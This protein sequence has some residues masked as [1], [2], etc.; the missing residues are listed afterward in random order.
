MVYSWSVATSIS[1][2]ARANQTHDRPRASESTPPSISVAAAGHSLAVD[3]EGQ[4]W[5]W[6]RNNSRGGGGNWY[7]YDGSGQL[8]VRLGDVRPTL[9]ARI[10]LPPQHRAARFAAVASG[11]YHS[12]AVTEGGELLTW[13]SNDHGQLGR[14]AFNAS[15]H[16]EPCELGWYCRD[17]WPRPVQGLPRVK[18]AALGRFNSLAIDEA[19]QIWVWGID[20]CAR[21]DWAAQRRKGVWPNALASAQPRRVPIRE[22]GQ[23]LN[24]TDASAGYVHWVAV[25]E[26]G[27]VW[28]CATADDGYSGMLMDV[29]KGWR[30]VNLRHELGHQ[31][32]D[33]Q[34]GRVPGV[35]TAVAVTAG[36]CSSGA[37]LADG[38]I[39]QWG[40]DN[41]LC[42]SLD[43]AHNWM[44]PRHIPNLGPGTEGGPVAQFALGEW[45]AAAVGVD[46]RFWAWGRVNVT[47]GP[48]G[49]STPKLPL[50]LEGTVPPGSSAIALATKHQHFLALVVKTPKARARGG[51]GDDDEGAEDAEQEALAAAAAEGQ[52][53]SWRGRSRAA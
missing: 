39:V 10:L 28:T 3:E 1:G 34:P 46:G 20:Q 32:K 53:K 48:C 31:V 37:R 7:T 15:R 6:G 25:D 17:P 30:P 49:P 47:V 26:G 27:G 5:T 45:S 43:G 33:F 13:G 41:M 9:P 42:M 4:I 16:E 18:R 51:G 40:C 14:R 23:L 44:E 24:F 52:A 36:R 8:G 22:G 50:L 2:L 21:R 29:H 12:A 19:G 35:N 38:S 11:R